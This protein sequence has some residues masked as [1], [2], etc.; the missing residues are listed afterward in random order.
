MKAAALINLSPY[1]SWVHLF[2]EKTIAPACGVTFWCG[3]QTGDLMTREV[4]VEPGQIFRCWPG[5]TNPNAS[6]VGLEAGTTAEEA[7][8][9]TTCMVRSNNPVE[10]R[11]YTRFG[12][13]MIPVANRTFRAEPPS[14][15]PSSNAMLSGLA[16]SAGTLIPPSSAR[17]PAHPACG[18]RAGVIYLDGDRGATIRVGGGV[19]RSGTRSGAFRVNAGETHAISITGSAQDGMTRTYAVTVTRP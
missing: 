16:V 6:E 1:Q 4:K 18:H 15:A 8:H 9:Q 14:P 3:Q 19:V 2:C 10:A 17:R 5:K 7:R 11:A 13:E 12:G